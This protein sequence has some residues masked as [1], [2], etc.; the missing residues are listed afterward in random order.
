[1]VKT[2]GKYGKLLASGS[3]QN[4]SMGLQASESRSGSGE[5]RYDAP[6]PINPSLSSSLVL[7]EEERDTGELESDATGEPSRRLRLHLIFLCKE[8]PRQPLR[9]DHPQPNDEQQT[10]DP[11]I[12]PNVRAG[13]RI[14]QDQQ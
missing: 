9:E 12:D 8:L 1:M 7:R 10:A 6:T 3:W 2:K 11:E 4:C 5:P 13:N 14:D